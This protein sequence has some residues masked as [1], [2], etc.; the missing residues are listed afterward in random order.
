MRF[1]C[2]LLLPLLTAAAELHVGQP[3]PRLEFSQVLQSAPGTQLTWETLKGDAVVLEFWATWCAGCVEEIGHLNRLSEAMK[4][5]P[6][7]FISATDEDPEVVHRFL[8]DYKMSGWVALDA[9]G[10]TFTN[11]GVIGRPL[12]ILVDKTGVIR[13]IG[14]PS[15]LS[16]DL[17]ERLLDGKEINFSDRDVRANSRQSLPVPFFEAMIRPAA[18]VELTGYSKGAESGKKGH[19]F[20]AWGVTLK[21]I[22]SLAYDF[23]E[24]RILAPPWS[25]ETRYD[26]SIA[27]PELS[28]SLQTDLITRAL[29]TTFNLQT[30]K[31]SRSTEVYVLARQPG[32]TPNLQQATSKG[33]SGWGKR[34]DIKMVSVSLASLAGL[35]SSVL[36]RPVLN[37][38]GMQGK[39]DIAI[40]WD[41]QDPNSL[42]LAVEQQL[43]LKLILTQRPLEYL[44]VDSAT[45]PKAW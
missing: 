39:F 43:T 27:A 30:H 5:K 6:V 18:P 45:E 42:L 2:L 24:S 31:E 14:N 38:T 1:L 37:E 36:N 44:V 16:A 21:H 26:V 28:P 20:Q 13:G 32:I 12:T 4:D 23:D 15:E 11:F 33:S 29:Q 19:D 34:G 35:A 17:I 41:P 25:S 8:K 40:K 7:R 22:L 10:A 3:A 9:N